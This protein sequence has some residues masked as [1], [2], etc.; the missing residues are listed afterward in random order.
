MHEQ[1]FA[2]PMPLPSSYPASLPVVELESTVRVVK[3]KTTRGVS[4]YKINQNIL[5]IVPKQSASDLLM[6]APGFYVAHPEGDAIAQR[7]FLRG[8][9][10]EHGQDIEFK[11]SG[12]PMNQPS[13]IH[14]QGYADLNLVI[15]EV[16][17][18]LQVTEGVYAPQQ[19]DFS[20][21]GTV[22]YDLGVTERK[23]RIEAS[24]GSFQSVRGL[25]LFAPDKQ[26]EETFGAA[27]IKYSQGFG[28][29]VRGHLSGGALGQ[30]RLNLSDRTH[31]LFHLGGYVAR[32][33]LAGVLRRDDIDAG[34]VGFYDAYKDPTARA[35]SAGTGRIQLSVSLTH[36][37]DKGALLQSSLY[38]YWAIYRS[39]LN[40]TGYTER[41][42]N[43]A[44]WI[45][46][47]DLTE[48]SNNDFSLGGT[49]SYQSS[50]YQPWSW[51]KWRYELGTHLRFNTIEQTQSLLKVPQNEIWDT[52]DDADL[53]ALGAGF[54]AD[55]LLQITSYI[56]IKGGLRSDVLF[57]DVNDKLGNFIP[58]FAIK[59]HLIGYRRTAT[60]V[61]LLPRVTLEVQPLSWLGLLAAYGQG[62][63][64]PQARQL[65]EGEQAPF[66]RV[67]SIDAGFKI[68]HQT[69]FKISGS[70]YQTRLSY[71]LAFDPNSARLERLGPT[72]RTGMSL[73]ILLEPWSFLSIS[74]HLTYVHASL[75]SPP[76]ATVS[77]PTPAFKQGQLMPYVP[78]WVFHTDIG[79]HHTIAHLW[80][81][82]LLLKAGSSIT[83]LSP[84]PLP[85]QEFSPTV[86][87]LDA[88]IGLR[89]DFI[90]IGI[91][92]SNL[93]NLKYAQTEYSY[94][95]YWQ[96]AT[97]PSRVPMRHISAGAPFTLMGHISFY[98]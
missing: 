28:P 12:V 88:S 24:Y 87:L 68:Q 84:R 1:V 22:D 96:T 48:Q 74:T 18:S 86:T 73:Q 54:Y 9:D 35:Q 52:R 6:S 71:D 63:R 57:F 47:G 36:Q 89:R 3:D 69:W 59:N 40:F 32:A 80:G 29:Y 27:H 70:F 14:G 19:G 4:D 64:S 82:P 26:P 75:D 45:G 38:T 55:L 41:S 90:E 93:L 49:L 15:P 39:R 30:Y 92:G 20:V 58:Q 76:I 65:E 37:L 42:R 61:A 95:S 81:K 85:Y 8:F 23:S 17:R 31:V 10:A 98:F 25:V 13:H 34:R 97:V 94:V 66:A 53:R 51:F 67:S 77:V 72:T 43:N 46:F 78:P 50:R 33:S 11:V 5:N 44:Q 2:Q 62:Y 56:R 83:V 16:V 7:V 60:G 21:A 91:D 79:F